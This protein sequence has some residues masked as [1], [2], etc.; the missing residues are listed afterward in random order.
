MGNEP[1]LKLKGWSIK[2]ALAVFTLFM[3]SGSLAYFGIIDLTGYQK[4]IL[5]VAAVMIVF[6]EIGLIGIIRSKGKK[7]LDFFSALGLF[8]GL[9]ILSSLT[10]EF[11]GVSGNFITNMNGVKG[12]VYAVLVIDFIVEMFR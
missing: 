10:L 4:Q 5:D 8:S 2:V 11:F 1:S 7:G 9:F 6:I 12:V 3:V